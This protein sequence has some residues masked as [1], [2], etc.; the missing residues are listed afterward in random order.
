MAVLP[1]TRIRD[2]GVVGTVTD[3]PLTIS[4][5][6]FNSLNLSK[7]GVV[8]NDHAIVTLDPLRQYGEP[9]IIMV[10]SHTADATVATI[11]RGMYGT[12]ARAHPAGTLWV[13][14]AVSNDF[15]EIVTSTSRP[16]DPYEGQI[17]Y[18]ND[19]NT[20]KSFN[21]TAWVT[22][23]GE[24]GGGVSD[25]GD[26]S[27][28]A[29]DDHTQYQLRTEKGIAN[30]YAGLD[31]TGTVPLAQLPSTLAQDSEVTSAVSTHAGAADP[32][33]GYQKESEKD[34]NN[35]YA[36]LDADGRVPESRIATTIARDTEVTTAVS[37]HAGEA[38]PH[39]GYQKE[40]EKGAANGYASLDGS[41]LVP[42]AQ[43]GTGT[44]TITNFLR[45]DGTWAVPAGGGGGGASADT[46][47]GGVIAYYGN[48]AP[49]GWL[50]CDGTAIPGQYTELIALVGANTPNFK[51][52]V[53]VGRDA[54]QT[55]FDV[56]GETGGAKTHT[57]TA[58]EMPSHTHVQN[59]HTHEGFSGASPITQSGNGLVAGSGNP[60][61][62]SAGQIATGATAVNQ[63][64]GG[65]GAHNNLQP[66]A[67]VNW[68]I[69]AEPASGS[70]GTSD[71]E[72]IVWMGGF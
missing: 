41:T 11:Q 9:E 8:L 14:A 16:T 13:H 43:L 61:V 62:V 44:P 64:T 59:A 56:L 46:P 7:L 58:A 30:G 60:T 70:G 36:G 65:G 18:E 17:I 48:T 10:T 38:D 53:L 37:T 40:S 19:T 51:G 23:G 26:L 22:L 28:L 67:V 55:E 15:I 52:R 1:G 24:G 69:K 47:V 72:P 49:D 32:H 66:Y 21:G 34:Q 68:I 33:I 35:G 5:T 4:A 71:I 54:A 6:T 12:P 42:K 45:G 27:G 39:T 63:T 3:N 31:V 25:H 20:Y 2:N 29:D 50:L 57:L